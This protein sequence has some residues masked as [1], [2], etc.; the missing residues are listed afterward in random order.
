MGQSP[1]LLGGPISPNQSGLQPTLQGVKV[2]DE[3]LTPQQR[4]HRE[5]QLAAL[6]KMQILLFPEHKE[7]SIPPLDQQQGANPG[8][9]CAPTNMPPVSAPS[10]DWHKIQNPFMD[11]KNKVSIISYF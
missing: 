5:A 6:R 9:S 7:D 3:E 8:S 1:N 2:P 10:M 11:G 4:Q